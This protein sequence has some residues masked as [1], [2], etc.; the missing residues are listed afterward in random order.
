MYV[1][2]RDFFFFFLRNYN[3]NFKNTVTVISSAVQ[4]V[5]AVKTIGVFQFFWSGCQKVMQ[6]SKGMRNY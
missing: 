5:T 2:L 1:K 3:Y 4:L 6:A